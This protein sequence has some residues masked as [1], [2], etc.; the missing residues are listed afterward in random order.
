MANWRLH[1]SIERHCTAISALM[2]TQY[3]KISK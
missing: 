2:F 3:K 1:V